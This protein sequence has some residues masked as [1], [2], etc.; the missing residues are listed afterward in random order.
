MLLPLWVLRPILS[1]RILGCGIAR[2][3]QIAFRLV[4]HCEKLFLYLLDCHNCFYD[5]LFY[6]FRWAC[7]CL[8]VGNYIIVK[9]KRRYK[10]R[11]AYCLLYYV[12]HSEKS[13]LAF[14]EGVYCYL[15]GGVEYAGDIAASSK[16]IVG[17]PEITKFFV[18]GF[19]ES[20]LMYVGK[21]CSFDLRNI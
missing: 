2:F 14:E 11:L 17:E 6:L 4:C 12:A 16:G 20:K 18:I 13:Y 15:V 8:S 21:V 3:I 7:S 19:L 5:G 1:Y 10:C 9:N